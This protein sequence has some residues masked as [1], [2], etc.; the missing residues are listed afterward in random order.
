[1][2]SRS[3]VPVRSS[4]TL[5]RTELTAKQYGPFVSSEVS[6]QTDESANRSSTAE[7]VGD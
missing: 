3:I 6:V 5:L 1:M 4:R 7:V 2:A